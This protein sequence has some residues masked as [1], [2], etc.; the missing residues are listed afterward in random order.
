M[1]GRTASSD[2]LNTGSS[3]GSGRRPFHIVGPGYQTA[4]RMARQSR[5]GL[6]IRRL[7]WL[8]DVDG[9]DLAGPSL[10]TLSKLK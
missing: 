5:E 7:K 3:K 1:L 10:T 6:H 8:M 9:L 2:H 4:D